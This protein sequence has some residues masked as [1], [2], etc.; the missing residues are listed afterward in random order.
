MGVWY[1]F[2]RLFGRYWIQQFLIPEKAFRLI[3]TTW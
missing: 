2:V 1:D 3:A